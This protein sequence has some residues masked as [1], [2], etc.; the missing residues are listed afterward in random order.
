MTWQTDILSALSAPTTANNVSKMTAWNACEGNK[1]GG[2]GLPINNPFNTTLSYGGG[3]SVNSAGVKAYPSWQ[4]G[5]QATVNTLASGRYSGVVTNLRND[6]TGTQFAAAV[7]NSGWGTSG[8]CIAGALGKSASSVQPGGGTGTT[9]NA[10]NVQ[11]SYAQLEGIWIQAGG[12]PQ[13]AA[14]AAAVAMAESGGHS[15]ASNTNTNGSVDRGL[16]QINSVHGTQSTFDI[17][18]NARAA[19]A[20][21]NNG[22]NWSPWV[23]FNTGAYKKFLQSNVAPDLTVSING[24]NAQLPGQS[25]DIT[26]LGPCNTWETIISPGLCIGAGA[27]G[28]TATGASKA[29]AGAIEGVAVAI[30]NPLIQIVAGVTGMLGGGILMLGGAYM[31]VQQSN[32]YK[33][34]SSA[35]QS[36]SQPRNDSYSMFTGQG[37]QPKDVAP[38]G[39][40]TSGGNKAVK[41]QGTAEGLRAEAAKYGKVAVEA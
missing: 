19:V 37:G 14:I 39:Q 32:T 8:S 25:A 33:N 2:S 27:A 15:G 5:V 18:G 38:R 31:L 41:Q 28:S 1:T 21:S 23:T 4:T 12:N 16:W 40:G 35:A 3:V 9:V 6:G 20:I 29:V 7:G 11:F 36:M 26:G 30:L 34:A 22:G 10:S 13:S 24:T 17:M